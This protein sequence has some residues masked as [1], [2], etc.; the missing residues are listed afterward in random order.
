[1]LL[2]QDCD[3]GSRTWIPIKV[4]DAF[5]PVLSLLGWTSIVLLTVETTVPLLILTVETTVPLLLASSRGRN[6]M[7]GDSCG[8]SVKM[9]SRILES[10]IA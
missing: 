9:A 7:E 10:P 8:Q 3:S 2:S 4:L 5:S 6:K 1:M